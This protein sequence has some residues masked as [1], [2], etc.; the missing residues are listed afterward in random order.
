M[1]YI[2]RYRNDHGETVSREAYRSESQHSRDELSETVPRDAV[3][4]S[5]A[6]H[7]VGQQVNVSGVDREAVRVHC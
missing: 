7:E 4:G 5:S 1:Q 3:H 2:A 6:G